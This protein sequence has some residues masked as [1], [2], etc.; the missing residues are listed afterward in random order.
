MITLAINEK[1]KAGKAI[2]ATAKKL[3]EQSRGIV[4]VKEEDDT[5]L[6]KK[7]LLARNSGQSSKGDIID[8]LDE[9]IAR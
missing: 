8:F 6:L 5:Q 1:S 7:M 4:F 2:L 9:I 3:A